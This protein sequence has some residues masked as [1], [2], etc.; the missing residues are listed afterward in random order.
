MDLSLKTGAGV[1]LSNGLIEYFG[2]AGIRP[3]PRARVLAELEAAARPLRV[4]REP[5]MSGGP[6]KGADPRRRWVVSS[7][8]CLQLLKY[9]GC[10]PRRQ[11]ESRPFT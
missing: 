11:S 3:A 1:A 9:S 10:G 8:F 5:A 2:L 4:S 6:K 7:H